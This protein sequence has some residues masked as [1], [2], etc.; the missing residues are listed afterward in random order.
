[1]K[2]GNW[3]INL[4]NRTGAKS[5]P[6]YKKIYSINRNQANTKIYINFLGLNFSHE[7]KQPFNIRQV[8]ADMNEV[9]ESGL[10]DAKYYISNHHPE[11]RTY[12][13][14]RYYVT[15]GYKNKEKPS[16]IFDSERYYCPIDIN[17]ISHFLNIGRYCYNPAFFKN[18]FPASEKTINKYLEEK[19]QRKSN[20][21]VYTCITNNYD[22][23]EE[24]K[25]FYY[26]DNS[27]DYI[28]F[29]DNEEDVSKGEI[30]IWEI[31]PLVYKE[32]D[33]SINNRYHK[34][35]P[36]VILPEYEESVYL[37][38]NINVLTPKFFEMLNNTDKDILL[39]KHTNNIDLYKEL[40]WAK[41][42]GFQPPETL[43]KLY[44]L[45]KQAGF[46]ENYGM[47]EN[48]IIYRRHKEPQIIEMMEEWWK[49]VSEY[50]KRD[51]ASFAYVFW[52]NGRK[53]E[54]HTFENTRIDYKNFCVFTHKKEWDLCK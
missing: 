45:I 48:N 53:F 8:F 51:Q 10:W 34:L 35:K 46:P 39:P 19:K 49:Y 11:M 41:N 30:G 14:L 28:C 6:F 52:K 33:N 37:D 38:A 1:M 2:I 54:D 44:E 24:L 13:A 12:D 26:T 36:H 32:A 18:E 20:K 40:L 23:I 3:E 16:K 42:Q 31:R 29:T 21:V 47:S 4:S 9:R 27:W 17:P 22:S 15:E 50:C 43:D 7:I 5:L 25:A